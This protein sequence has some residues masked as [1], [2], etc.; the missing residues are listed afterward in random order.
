MAVFLLIILTAAVSNLA[1]IIKGL[2]ADGFR[3]TF[4]VIA[5]VIATLLFAVKI[6]ITLKEF[7]K[8]ETKKKKKPEEKR[9][10]LPAVFLNILSTCL[11]AAYV[12]VII[13]GVYAMSD[14]DRTAML[15]NSLKGAENFRAVDLSVYGIAEEVPMHEK[16]LCLPALY[17]MISD[18][19]GL[20]IDVLVFKVIPILYL[21]LSACAFGSLAK[22]LFPENGRELAGTYPYRFRRSLF[23]VIVMFLI[24]VADSEGINGFCLISQGWSGASVSVWILMPYMIYSLVRVLKGSKK[25]IAT[26]LMT[27]AAETFVVW[28]AF[29]VGSTAF[30]AVGIST[31]YLMIKRRGGTHGIQEGADS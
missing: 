24:P 16:I 15:A 31:A 5:I 26:L 6:V 28:T 23:F 11:L 12:A 27:I 9:I 7:Q 8:E 22:V 10:L 30:A 29:G 4:A 20:G 14:G 13:S 21:I 17:A 19:T 1:V 25:H 18:A 3:R 2:G